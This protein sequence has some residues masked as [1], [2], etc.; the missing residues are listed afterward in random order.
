MN[1]SA[2][3]FVLNWFIEW[4]V[5]VSFMESRV[6]PLFLFPPLSVSLS[7]C[8]SLSLSLF[9]VSMGRYPLPFNALVSQARRRRTDKK[10]NKQTNKQTH[11]VVGTHLFRLDPAIKRSQKAT[12]KKN[13][14]SHGKQIHPQ[15]AKKL[16]WQM[17]IRRSARRTGCTAGHSNG[18]PARNTGP[19]GLG[20]SGKQLVKKVEHETK[21]LAH[22]ATHRKTAN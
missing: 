5:A 21:W 20:G 11:P 12:N 8:L 13:E 9:E 7:L 16:R 18:C 22:Q 4:M 3:H 17:T 14:R 15:C 1:R 19:W 2:W 10:T 6:S